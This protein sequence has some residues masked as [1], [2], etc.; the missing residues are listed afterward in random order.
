MSFPADF[1]PGPFARTRYRHGVPS[2]S[3]VATGDILPSRFVALDRARDGRVQQAAG[4]DSPY[5]I[6]QAE[7]R[8]APY[9]PSLAATET[10]AAADGESVFVYGPYAAD[11]P[12][13]Y[14]GLV[15]I[16]DWL[17]SDDLGRGVQAGAGDWAGAVAQQPGD[18]GQTKLVTVIAAQRVRP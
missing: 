14:G 18:A 10:R 7:L 15:Q 16:G 6:S 13:V 4:G 17:T 2:Y 3:R 12:L 5:G 9:N 11:V 8:G 1:Q